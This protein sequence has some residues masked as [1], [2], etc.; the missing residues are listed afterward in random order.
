MLGGGEAAE[1]EGLSEASAGEGCLP[2]ESP[3][4]GVVGKGRPG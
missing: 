4:E 1:A 2:G 3:R